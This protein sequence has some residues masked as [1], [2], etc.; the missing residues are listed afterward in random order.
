MGANGLKAQAAAYAALLLGFAATAKSH[1]HHMGNIEEGKFVSNEPL[2]RDM[3]WRIS[4]FGRGLM[5]ALGH[6]TMGTH[7]G[8]DAGMGNLV[9][10]GNGLGSRLPRI[11]PLVGHV[12]TDIDNTVKMA[13]PRTDD[14]HRARHSGILPWTQA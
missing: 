11:Q 5:V 8:A 12:L 13:R 14:R 7:F 4:T 9:P 2:V 3:A 10:H 6:D 1:E